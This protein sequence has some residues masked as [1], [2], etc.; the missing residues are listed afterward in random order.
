MNSAAYCHMCQRETE[1]IF[2]KLSSGH[3]GNCCSVCRTTRKGHPYASKSEYH[4]RC[5]KAEGQHELQTSSAC[6]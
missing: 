6:N 4:R 2:L 3:I 1:T 5:Q